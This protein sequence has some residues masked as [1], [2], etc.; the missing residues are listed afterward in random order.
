MADEKAAT[1]FLQRF[2]YLA[3]DTSLDSAQGHAAVRA[4]QAANLLP[5][6]GDLDSRT[7][8]QFARPRCGLPDRNAF[9]TAGLAPFVAFGTVWDRAVITYRINNLS[10]DFGENRQRQIVAAAW[11]QWAAVVPLVFRETTGTPDIEILFGSRDHGDGATHSFDGPGR[12]LAHAFFPPPNGG[13]LAGDAHFDEDETWQDGVSASGIDLFTVAVHEFGH[14]L[15]LDH[16][17]V[18]N[19]TMNPFYPT[20]STPQQDDRAGMRQVYRRQIW[21]ASMYR[22]ILGRRFDDDGLDGWVR[23]LFAGGSPEGMARGFCYSEEFSTDLATELYFLLLDRQPDP[24]GLAGWRKQLQHGMGRQSAIVGFLDSPEYR[25]KY[26]QDEAFV[27]SL[28]RRLLNRAPD[29]GGFQFW[30]KQLKNGVPRSEVAR[31]FVLSPE[32]CRNFSKSLYVHYLRRQPDAGGWQ[33]WTDLL[34]QG[35][36]H[37]DAIAGFVSSTEY[38]NAVVNWW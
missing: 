17:T 21:V 7:E 32:Y 38:Q 5:A 37:Q 19:S 36:N 34:T 28:Y 23:S 22:D 10:G 20:P 33:F 15:G 31:G 16:T 30:V 11:Q 3:D 25:S 12:V 4:F 13:S 14:S 1:D 18:P 6:T 24:G 35:M 27:D 9:T 26:P 2:G 8:E 29:A